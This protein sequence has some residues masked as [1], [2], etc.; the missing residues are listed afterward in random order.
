MLPQSEFIDMQF[1]AVPFPP[2]AMMLLTANQSRPT[3]RLAYKVR[4]RHGLSHTFERNFVG[5][6]GNSVKFG[7]WLR[8]IA[9]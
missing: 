7:G 9:L 5:P 3:C 4:F 6:L 2:S 8:L 1:D